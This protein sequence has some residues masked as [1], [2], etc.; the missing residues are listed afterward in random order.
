[1]KI[2]FKDSGLSEGIIKISLDGGYTYT[3]YNIA[4]VK[5]TGIILDDSQRY[6]KIK[7]KGPANVL[8]RLDDISTIQLDG[9]VTEGLNFIMDTDTYGFAF[10]KC[11]VGITLPDGITSITKGSTSSSSTKNIFS[12]FPN[13]HSV[14]IPNSVT[15]IGDESFK[16]CTSLTSINIPES[17]TSIGNNSFYGCSKLTSITIPEGVT[18]IGNYAFQSCSKLTSI[19]YTGAEEQWDLIS[20]GTDWNKSVHSDCQIVFNYVKE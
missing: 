1:M 9:E 16:S 18:S 12:N 7:I 19:N 3:D 15:S 5:E 13:L 2:V 4:D 17:V 10:P 8:K 6:D 20:K 14:V 11:V